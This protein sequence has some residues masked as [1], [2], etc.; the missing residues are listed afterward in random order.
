MKTLIRVAALTLALTVLSGCGGDDVD[1]A[2]DPSSR[3]PTTTAPTDKPTT[4]SYPEFG[5]AD[6]TYLLEQI[7]FCP[8]TGPV[9]VTVEDGEVT[10]AVTTERVPGMKKGSEAP[11]YLWIT[12]DDIIFRANDQGAAE[13]VVEWPDG[14][15]WPDSVAVDKV[16][17][18][19]DDEVVYKISDVQLG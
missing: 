7:C 9:R 6:Y 14:Q 13:V 8:I 16:E 4:G 5:A 17:N 1:T 12:I 15:A 10:S 19:T 2:S 3:T 11:E 18:A